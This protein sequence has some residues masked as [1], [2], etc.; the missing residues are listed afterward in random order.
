MQAKPQA[1]IPEQN[2]NEFDL[3][4]TTDTQ[5]APT[6]GELLKQAGYKALEAF[7]L[8]NAA[9]YIA[10]AAAPVIERADEIARQAAK[11]VRQSLT[12]SRITVDFSERDVS[13]FFPE[14]LTTTSTRYLFTGSLRGSYTNNMVKVNG[15][16]VEGSD[17]TDAVWMLACIA[18]EGGTFSFGG[19]VRNY[20]DTKHTHAHT[21]PQNTDKA[22]F[23]LEMGLIK[24]NELSNS[25]VEGTNVSLVVKILDQGSKLLGYGT[26][27]NGF[28]DDEIAKKSQR[29]N[30]LQEQIFTANP[31]IR[32]A[33]ESHRAQAIRIADA[34][35]LTARLKIEEAQKSPK[36]PATNTAPN[37]EQSAMAAT[38]EEKP[39]SPSASSFASDDDSIAP[40]AANTSAPQA[41]SV[42]QQIIASRQAS[43][44]RS[45]VKMTEEVAAPLETRNEELSTR[46]LATDATSAEATPL[47]PNMAA[48][49]EPQSNQAPRAPSPPAKQDEPQLPNTREDLVATEP[50]TIAPQPPRSESPHVDALQAQ[51]AADALAAATN[52]T[53]A[54]GKKKK[55]KGHR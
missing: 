43:P 32:L 33:L 6:T 41:A 25:K 36:R 27:I 50:E 22:I 12:L 31:E 37:T 40:V 13:D 4:E 29:L 9:T 8:H 16:D 26:A 5:T 54:G 39:N 48:T 45:H 14:N 52:T 15:S 19:D 55:G 23:S 21:K 30:E 24:L 53:G 38:T 7:G 35:A 1:P 49:E 10:T 2:E 34:K 18:N 44:T 28:T 51:R 17:M 46:A 47:A 42:A 20:L 3:V 11:V